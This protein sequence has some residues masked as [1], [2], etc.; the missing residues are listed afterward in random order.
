MDEV[1]VTAT[2]TENK[3]GNVAVPVQTISKKLIMQSGSMRLQD[4]LGETS[5]LFITNGGGTASAG[6]GVFG[7][8]VQLQG[9]S[10][11]YTLILLDGEPIIGRQGGVLDLSRITTGNIR[12]I[13]IVKGPSSSLYGSEAM[14]GVINIITDGALQNNLKAGLRYGRFGET[15]I[16]ISS[17]FKKDNW[18]L[19]AFGNR[20][21]SNGFDLHKDIVGKTIDLFRNYTGQLK[22]NVQLSAN[23]KINFSA[24]YFN[25]I[26]D[27]FFPVKD[28]NTA[29]DIN[30]SGDGKIRDLNFNPSLHHRFSGQVQTVLRTYFSRYEYEQQLNREDKSSYYYDFFNKVFIKQKTRPI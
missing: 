2:R 18:G 3:L 24:R 7:N 14:G 21:S 9:L 19:Q 22:G 11:D 17:S 12:K 5:G 27:N 10:P 20:N 4:I 6:G 28:I 26:Q 13:E 1:V 15:D 23:T 25:E 30:I 8:G 29:T 16:N